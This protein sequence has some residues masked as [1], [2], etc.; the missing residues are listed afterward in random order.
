MLLLVA[1]GSNGRPSLACYLAEHG[2]AGR[3]G[4]LEIELKKPETAVSEQQVSG[5]PAPQDEAKLQTTVARREKSSSGLARIAAIPFA[6]GML[7]LG[8][9]QYQILKGMNEAS[10][11]HW[12]ATLGLEVQPYGAYWRV[13]WNRS[14]ANLDGATRG[15]LRIEGGGLRKDVDLDAAELRTS[16]II[17]DA[18]GSEISVHLEVFEGDRSTSESLRVFAVLPAAVVAETAPSQIT[19]VPLH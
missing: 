13:T 9:Q 3:E 12:P 18:A 7:W 16:S 15:H 19:P 5:T 11:A 4:R 1:P 14:S 8:F 10:P 6:A 2:Q 17:Y